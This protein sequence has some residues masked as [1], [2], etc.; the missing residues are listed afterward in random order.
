MHDLYPFKSFIQ[1]PEPVCFTC[2][3]K[4]S[5]WKRSSLNWGIVQP[6]KTSTSLLLP[7][8]ICKKADPAMLGLQ[9]SAPHPARSCSCPTPAPSH[10]QSQIAALTRCLDLSKLEPNL[11]MMRPA[12]ACRLSTG[13]SI[14]HIIHNYWLTGIM[15]LHFGGRSKDLDTILYTALY[16]ALYTV[17]YTVLYTAV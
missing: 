12:G 8:A 5:R 6:R 3:W 9:C 13:Y 7:S 4:R 10:S 15:G 16:T 2:W 11:P 17:L 14:I 1:P